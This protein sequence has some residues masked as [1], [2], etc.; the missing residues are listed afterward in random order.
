MSASAV[1]EASRAAF[2]RHRA[3]KYLERYA[4][5]LLFASYALLAAGTSFDT[6][7]SEWTRRHWHFKRAL[8]DLSVEDE[9]APSLDRQGSLASS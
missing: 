7:F 2:W 5:V 4:Y 1:P 6:T 9:S 3:L 8:K